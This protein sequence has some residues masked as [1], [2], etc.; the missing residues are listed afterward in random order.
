[1][2]MTVSPAIGNRS[3][4]DGCSQKKSERDGRGL[5]KALASNK[6]CIFVDRI[7]IEVA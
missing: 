2:C 3:F 1:M 5:P 4:H 7:V 6:A